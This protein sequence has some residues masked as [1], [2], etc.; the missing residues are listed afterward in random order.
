M[1]DE[2][3]MAEE[4]PV[5]EENAAADLTAIDRTGRDPLAA[6]PPFAGFSVLWWVEGDEASR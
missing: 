5:D 3:A 2:V 6:A 1:S 4:I